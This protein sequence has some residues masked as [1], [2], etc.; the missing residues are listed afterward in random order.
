[1]VR[2]VSK[3]SSARSCASFVYSIIP[4]DL[5]TEGVIPSRS[6]CNE[7]ELAESCAMSHFDKH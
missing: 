2:L 5:S 1:M 4:N 6:V 7:S 3:I